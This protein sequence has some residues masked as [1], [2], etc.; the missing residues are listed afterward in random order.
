MP[1]YSA[2]FA[3]SSPPAAGPECSISGG[4]SET[5]TAPTSCVRSS[6]K[7]YPAGKT[8][9][10]T[11]NQDLFVNRQASRPYSALMSAALT[12]LPHFSVSSAMNL[13]KSAGEPGK[14]TPAS[15]AICAFSLGSAR[16]ALIS[17]FSLLTISTGVFLGAPTP[18]PG[19]R[20]EA[21][22]E[23]TDRRDIQKHLRARGSGYCQRSE[24][25]GPD[26]AD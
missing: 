12:T 5:W 22:H 15:S 6:T 24:L 8:L 1:R 2:R 16:P 20:L 13:P 9:Q 26:L 4:A 25:A 18:N 11:K 19:S 7:T 14:V 10:G 21:G 23:L 17:L 3:A